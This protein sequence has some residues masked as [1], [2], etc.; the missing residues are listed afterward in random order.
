MPCI[1]EDEASV[2]KH[3]ATSMEFLRIFVRN[4]S[5]LYWFARYP[6]V[7]KND[8][9]FIEEAYMQSLTYIAAP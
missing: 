3:N 9:S 2:N 4:T 6:F 5:L 8:P 7:S 1:P